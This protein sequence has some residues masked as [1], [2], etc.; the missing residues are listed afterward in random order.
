MQLT[1]AIISALFAASTTFAAPTAQPQGGYPGAQPQGG[2]PGAQ[3]QGG[4]PGAQPQ[5]GYQGAYPQKV[6]LTITN[7]ESGRNDRIT[8]PLDWTQIFFSQAFATSAITEAYSGRIMATRAEV[9]QAPEGRWYC[10]IY[11]L[12][13]PDI[14]TLDKYGRSSVVIGSHPIDL[15]GAGLRCGWY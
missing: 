14:V 13:G 3:P 1:F 5:G 12:G 15:S 10:V 7:N 2:Y 4:Y 9:N 11:H 8:A 6:V